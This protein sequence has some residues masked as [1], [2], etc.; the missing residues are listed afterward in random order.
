MR[1]APV[2]ISIRMMMVGLCV[3]GLGSFVAYRMKKDEYAH[4]NYLISNAEL[5]ARWELG[6]LSDFDT[7]CEWLGGQ[8]RVDFRPKDGGRKRPGRRYL[9]WSCSC[10]VDVKVT[11]LPLP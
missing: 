11:S 5:H 1:F 10:G 8:V 9:V 3:A 6:N 4:M 7:A 2:R